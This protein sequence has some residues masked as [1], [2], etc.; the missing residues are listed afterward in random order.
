MK[1]EAKLCGRIVSVLTSDKN[2]IAKIFLE[3]FTLINQNF[4]Y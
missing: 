4:D 3:T 1:L 2:C